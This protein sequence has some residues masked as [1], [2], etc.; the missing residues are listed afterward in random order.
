MKNQ[1]IEN[2]KTLYEKNSKHSNYQILTPKLEKL[3]GKKNITTKSRNEEKRLKYILKNVS[4]FQKKVIDVGGN[5]GYFSFSSLDSGAKHITYIEG[6]KNHSDF[7]SSAAE[8]LNYKEKI[9][10]VSNYVN[11]EDDTIIDSS[12]VFFLL[13]V[14]HHI[15]DDYGNI[16]DKN[17]ALN[18]I[19]NVLQKLSSKTTTLIFQLGFNWKGNPKLPFFENGTK[20]EMINF[21]K[22]VSDQHW[23]IKHI[24]IAE[25][26]EQEPVYKELNDTNIQR[27]NALGE[28]LN[29]P[30]FILETLIKK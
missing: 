26:I 7:V 17:I 2:L 21:I 3:I 1:E 23:N 19:T 11:L 27:I 10:I 9:S 4:I 6:N 29:R 20:L 28:F 22:K 25:S 30:I 15:G 14:L 24:G 18:H 13:N 16:S 12:D 5:T 8:A